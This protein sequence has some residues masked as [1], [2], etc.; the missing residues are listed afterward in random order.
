MFSRMVVQIRILVSVFIASFPTNNYK[1]S[2][3][4]IFV[5]SKNISVQRRRLR[6]CSDAQAA[7]RQNFVETEQNYESAKYAKRASRNNH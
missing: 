6:Y 7:L 5:G 2:N 1:S 3:K 4:I